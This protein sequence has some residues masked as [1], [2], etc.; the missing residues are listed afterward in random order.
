MSK[1]MRKRKLG[2]SITKRGRSELFSDDQNIFFWNMILTYYWSML[3]MLILRLWRTKQCK[4]VVQCAARCSGPIVVT[5]ESLRIRQNFFLSEGGQTLAEVSRKLGVLILGD[6]QSWT[7]QPWAFLS[8]WYYFEGWDWTKWL[9]EVPSQL[10]YSMNLWWINT[11]MLHSSVILTDKEVTGAEWKEM[12]FDS[13]AFS[14]IT[15]LYVWP[16]SKSY[17]KSGIRAQ[18]IR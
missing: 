14:L 1:D 15:G 6:V 10:N 17:S 7:R 13:Y 8:R 9:S 5:R 11:C 2:G 16:L 3:V 4:K 18:R 12:D